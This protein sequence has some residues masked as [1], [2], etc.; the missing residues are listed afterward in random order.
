MRAYLKFVAAREI[1]SGSVRLCAL[2]IVQTRQIE[3]RK[4]KMRGRD[5]ATRFER[6]KLQLQF[7]QP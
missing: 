7:A 2:L 5:G 3:N 4:V 6:R 1:L